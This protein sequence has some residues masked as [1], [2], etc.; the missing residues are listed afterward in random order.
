MDDLPSGDAPDIPALMRAAVLPAPGQPLQ[1][2][3]MATPRPQHGEVLVQVAGCGVCHTDLHVMRGEV[4][5]VTPCVLGHEISGTVVEVGDGVR[6]ESGL[7]PGA[8]VVGGFI[9]PCGECPACAEGRD[10]LCRPFFALN[11]LRGV[12]YDGSSRLQRS[13]GESL[14]MYSMG[15]LAEYAVVPATGLAL[16]PPELPLVESAVLGCAAL[17]AYGAVRRAADLRVGETVAVIAMGGVGSN[18][19]QMAR[20]LGASRVI[21]V[22]VDAATLATARNLGAT[23]LVNATNLDPV[24]A[25]RDLTGGRGVDVAFEALGTPATFRQ[26]TQILCDGGRLVAI[27]IA[28]ADAAA[29]VEITPLV[30]RSQRIIGSYGARTRTDLPAVGAM[31]AAGRVRPAATVSR[32]FTLDDADAAYDAL[33]RGDIVGRAVVRMSPPPSEAT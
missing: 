10:D 24:A 6:P 8:R 5:F 13:N 7:T 11:R 3:V 29:H 12:L 9:M 23:D 18:V 28:A 19:V 33:A 1:L 32:T 17:T 15:G 30:R 20:A 21:A 16:L 4:G 2:E 27:G 14:A 25:V 22:D 26:G 31:A